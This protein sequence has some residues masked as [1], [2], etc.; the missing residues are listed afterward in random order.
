MKILIISDIHSNL[1]A[2]K[3]IFFYLKFKKIDIHRCF[4]LGDIIG[5]GPFPNECIDFIKN[6]THCKV[7]AGNHEWAV[8]E[9]LS[10]NYFNENAKLA[11]MWTKKVLTKENMEYILNLPIEVN[12]EYNNIK[13]QFVHGSPLNKVEEYITNHYIAKQNF[14][15]M[16]RDVCF[17]GH[18]HI[19]MLYLW[20]KNDV[21]SLY[22]DDGLTV[23]IRRGYKYLINIGA[24]GQP[25][26]GDPRAS[27]GILDTTTNKLTIK[28][29]EYNYRITQRYIMN[30]GLPTFLASRLGWG[31]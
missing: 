27:F 29:V 25:R 9:K 3:E 8:S 24:A 13:Y 18:T 17:F 30:F 11:I 16:K 12:A 20:H 4:V 28:R 31:R 7:I 1:E 6:I 23:K 15:V 26:D 14:S 2:L 5:Y 22:L 21:S 19:P 10:L